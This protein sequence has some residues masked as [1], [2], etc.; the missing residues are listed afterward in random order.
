[1]PE[2]IPAD[3][4]SPLGSAEYSGGSLE[5]DETLLET[6]DEEKI[7]VRQNSATDMSTDGETGEMPGDTE[8]VTASDERE[9]YDTEVGRSAYRPAH[10]EVERLPGASGRPNLPVE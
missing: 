2:C 3:F 7:P 8:G 1:M 4:S 9:L 10:P 5:D 6:M